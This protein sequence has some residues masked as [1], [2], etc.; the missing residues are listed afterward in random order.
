MASTGYDN[1]SYVDDN[2]K[3]LVP[4]N[5]ILNYEVFLK[6]IPLEKLFNNIEF[7]S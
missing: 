2:L 5:S 1:R 3:Q 4:L 6:N 7:F